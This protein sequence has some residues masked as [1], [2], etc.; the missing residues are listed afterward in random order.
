MKN[1]HLDCCDAF[2]VQ[3]ENGG[4]LELFGM[5]PEKGSFILALPRPEKDVC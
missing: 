2:D 3:L 5:C 1:V 4:S